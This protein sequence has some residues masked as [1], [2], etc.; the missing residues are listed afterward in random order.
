MIDAQARVSGSIN[1]VLN[2]EL[3]GMLCGKILRSPLP[4]A[5]IVKLDGSRAERLA[6]VGAVLTRG[7]F[8]SPAGFNGRYGRIF[9]DQTV[10][11]LDKVRF[12]GDPVAAVAAVN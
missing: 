10:V 2:T 12:V 6:G 3:A 4:H 11:A 7:D 8:T 9:C 5:R 1:Y